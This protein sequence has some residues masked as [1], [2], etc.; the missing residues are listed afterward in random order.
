MLLWHHLCVWFSDRNS[1]FLLLA[2]RAIAKVYRKISVSTLYTKF[3]KRVSPFNAVQITDNGGAFSIQ[4]NITPEKS[5]SCEVMMSH[6]H[7]PN[8]PWLVLAKLYSQSMV[9]VIFDCLLPYLTIY[10]KQK[11]LQSFEECTVGTWMISFV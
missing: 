7:G 10:H 3:W 6:W 2:L 5:L 11:W 9:R 1:K 4:P 8:L